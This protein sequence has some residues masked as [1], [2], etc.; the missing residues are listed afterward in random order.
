MR[1][2]LLTVDYGRMSGDRHVIFPDLAFASNSKI[3]RLP[4]TNFPATSPHVAPH[5]TASQTH[6]WPYRTN[7]LTVI[8]S[9]MPYIGEN[10]YD[11]LRPAKD[12]QH[13]TNLKKTMGRHSFAPVPVN[14]QSGGQTSAPSQS[15]YYP[16]PP[17]PQS[18]AARNH[19]FRP[20]GFGG[21]VGWNQP[22]YGQYGHGQP[23]SGQQYQGSPYAGPP[24]QQHGG[25][26]AG[27]QGT[28]NYWRQSNDHAQSVYSSPQADQGWQQGYSGQ[29]QQYAP[30]PYYAPYVQLG[31]QDQ[32]INQ[33]GLTQQWQTVNNAATQPGGTLPSSQLNANASAFK[34][35]G[36]LKS[37]PA[38]ELN[39]NYR[40]DKEPRYARTKP[41]PTTQS[42][43]AAPWHAQVVQSVG[44]AAHTRSFTGAT[45][46][47]HKPKFIEPLVQNSRLYLLKR[48][49]PSA[50]YMMQATEDPETL[51]APR[52]LLVILDL[53]G[54][55]LYRKQ[56]G[57]SSFQARPFVHEFLQYLF[58][59]H[60]VMVWS[61][62][63][64]KNVTNMITKLVPEDKD[65]L[66]AVWSRDD[67]RL[68]NHAY[69]E[70]VQVYKQLSWVWSNKAI[71]AKS[72]GTW[73]QANTILID[74]SVE[75][76]ASEPYNIVQIDEF[77]GKPEQMKVDVLGQV[78]KYMETLRGE[79]DVSAYM[80][81]KPFVFD[82]EMSFDLKRFVG[83]EK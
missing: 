31:P 52:P 11:R 68:S 14:Q 39:K 4:G 37:V 49:E 54:T 51:P 27:A 20:G 58:K 24:W 80:R 35:Q 71:Q 45:A 66:I 61:S 47:A 67:L 6:F 63:R 32:Q 73:S 75:K 23:F 53:N 48:P 77:E 72:P 3:R 15:G 18:H 2:E 60:H 8:G 76:A 26:G 13:L 41:N 74:D 44:P 33:H 16:L 36:P 30:S 22:G 50:E 5:C 19:V 25:Y 59:Y 55:L 29:Y 1:S 21:Q 56:R 81:T 10:R 70:K 40:I 38:A 78:V 62:A 79:K 82:P 43:A 34:P 42:F 28:F 65:K 46:T 57:G 12:T 64:P 69:K 17:R 83:D 7:V 9:G